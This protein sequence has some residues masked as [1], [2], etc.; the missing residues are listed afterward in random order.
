MEHHHTTFSEID[1]SSNLCNR[2]RLVMIPNLCLPM[3]YYIPI[4]SDYQIVIHINIVVLV[5]CLDRLRLPPSALLFA[6][7]LLETTIRDRYYLCIPCCLVAHDCISDLHQQSNA[8]RIVYIQTYL[9]CFP[10]KLSCPSAKFMKRPLYLH[11]H[12]QIRL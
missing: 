11:R 12:A 8:S 5:Q 4:D 3:P 7:L 10:Q 9:I 2:E 1:C 6:L